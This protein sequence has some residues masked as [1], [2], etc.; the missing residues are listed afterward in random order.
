MFGFVVQN[1]DS[2]FEKKKNFNVI[3]TSSFFSE[4]EEQ[5]KGCK[6][7][8][9]CLDY[10]KIY[11]LTTITSF[12]PKISLLEKDEE[13]R[14]D[15]N[16]FVRNLQVDKNSIVI[17]RYNASVPYLKGE[18]LE[19]GAFH[20]PTPVKEGIRV[21]YVDQISMSEI[22]QRF[23]EFINTYCVYPNV[24]DN[25]EILSKIQS[26]TY[27]FIIAN[28]MIEHT[29]N[30][31][32]TINNH[33]RVLKKGG[34]LFYAVPDKRFTFDID[35]ELTTYEHLKT[36]FIEGSQKNRYA[37]FVDFLTNVSNIKEEEKLHAAAKK[38]TEEGLDT[39]FHVWTSETF[40]E[41]I[42]LAIEDKILNVKVLEHT[43]DVNIESITILEKL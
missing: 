37:H 17:S 25:G 34:I 39:H 10:R 2:L 5:L 12:V 22:K 38:S 18:G 27:D 40:L 33:L 1:P 20:L 24:I 3:I 11:D 9:T 36:E 19:I 21:D 35:R 7:V 14:E 6:N 41:H 30:F 23:P 15:Y 31:F 16:S 43:H 8:L 26:E 32:K 29:E 13:L 28:H 4:I 42:E